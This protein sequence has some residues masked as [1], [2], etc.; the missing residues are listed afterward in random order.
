MSFVS[1]NAKKRAESRLKPHE[2]ADDEQFWL[3]N[4]ATLHLGPTKPARPFSHRPYRSYRACQ[5]LYVGHRFK[6]VNRIACLG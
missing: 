5:G 2:W 3:G 6:C 1:V 4:V